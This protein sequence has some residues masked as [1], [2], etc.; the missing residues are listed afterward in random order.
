MDICFVFTSWIDKVTK[1]LVQCFHG[2]QVLLWQI[3]I[4]Y[5]YKVSLRS[6]SRPNKTEIILPLE[7]FFWHIFFK[8]YSNKLN[9]L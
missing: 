5:Q 1:D 2:N 7:L 8:Q 6:L 9:Q 4:I 3:P